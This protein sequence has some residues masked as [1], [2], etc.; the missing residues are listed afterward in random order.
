MAGPF[1]I[2]Q[3]LGLPTPLGLPT[4]TPAIH[5]VRHLWREQIKCPRSFRLGLSAHASRPLEP[6]RPDRTAWGSYCVVGTVGSFDSGA[7]GGDSASG[8]PAVLQL[9]SSPS[10]P[11]PS[12]FLLGDRHIEL[13]A[14][15]RGQI[16]ASDLLPE[17]FLCQCASGMAPGRWLCRPWCCRCESQSFRR[18]RLAWGPLHLI[19]LPGASALLSQMRVA[20]PAK[21]RCSV[22]ALPARLSQ[23]RM[24]TRKAAQPGIKSGVTS[25]VYSFF[26]FCRPYHII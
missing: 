16:L 20:R 13:R 18:P 7:H 17:R 6:C 3:E 26:Q 21:P 9:I 12:N 11:I 23:R 5:A 8:V 15:L 22:G 14:A 1:E 25:W 10:H 19:C 4:A 24:G 2:R